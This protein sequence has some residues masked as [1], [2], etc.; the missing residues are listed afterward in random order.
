MSNPRDLPR[1]F[2]DEY[3]DWRE[4]ASNGETLL[5]FDEWIHVLHP[6]NF[7]ATAEP[8]VISLSS[9]KMPST[10][11]Q[12]ADLIIDSGKV[13]KNRYGVTGRLDE[14]YPPDA[15]LAFRQGACIWDS[16]SAPDRQI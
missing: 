11:I 6:Q 13:L 14:S 9:L 15:A 2:P 7:P 16:R 12:R 4:E 1:T 5:G 10:V 3:G 8:I